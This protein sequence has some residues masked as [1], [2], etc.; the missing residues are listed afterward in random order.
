MDDELK[1]K[2]FYRS[3]TDEN[4]C[5]GDEEIGAVLDTIETDHGAKIAFNED[6]DF[7]GVLS[8]YKT[9]YK[10]QNSPRKKVKNAVLQPLLITK[11]TPLY[12]IAEFMG[13]EKVFLLPVFE[14]DTVIGTI[15]AVD[16]VK[17]IYHDEDLK[18]ATAGELQED[19]PVVQKINAKVKDIYP[20]LRENGVGEVIIVDKVGKVLGVVT[21]SDLKHAF[22]HPTSK[23]RFHKD[24]YRSDDISFDTEKK[25]REDDPIRNYLT[26]RVPVTFNDATAQEKML[27]LL[28]S[29]SDFIVITDKASRPTGIL[30]FR[31]I[32]K[33]IAKLKPE[34]EVNITFEKPSRNVSVNEFEKAYDDLFEFVQK[35][36]KRLPLE[37]VEVRVHEPKF[38]TKETVEYDI[39]LQIDPLS[40][41]QYIA[42]SKAKIFG[43]SL[44]FAIKQIEK[45]FQ[46]DH[47]IKKSHQRKSL[48]ESSSEV[49]IKRMYR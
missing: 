41:G 7:I 26:E 46:K 34:Q 42:H 37:R 39:T 13:S 43:Q 6:K 2:N 40:G 49:M 21:R 48:S 31:N 18:I 19:K 14:K 20:L 22:I 30:S 1:A 35:M 36:N 3:L 28:D 24:N 25:L 15:A 11:E 44:R 29:D 23:Q 10:S 38:T 32:L 9:I 33:A 17:R 4:T 27:A 8:A 47:A 45:Q 12:Q 16:I 5:K